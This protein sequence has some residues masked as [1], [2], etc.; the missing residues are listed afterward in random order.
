M[1]GFSGI[2]TALMMI[3]TTNQSEAQVAAN[4]AGSTIAAR[5]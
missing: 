4:K 2:K 3:G 5:G 1:G